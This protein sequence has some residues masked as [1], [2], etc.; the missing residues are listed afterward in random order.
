[1]H[2]GAASLRHVL[3]LVTAAIREPQ[4]RTCEATAKPLLINATVK[5]LD[6]P[7]RDCPYWRAMPKAME[8]SFSQGSLNHSAASTFTR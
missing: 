1:L 3:Q 5:I 7:T 8:L 2:T 6:L 4:Y